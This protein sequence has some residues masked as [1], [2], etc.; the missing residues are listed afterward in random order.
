MNLAPDS[1]GFILKG[2]AMDNMIFVGAKIDKDTAINLG[3]FVED[4]TLVINCPWPPTNIFFSGD[5]KNDD[6]HEWWGPTPSSPRQP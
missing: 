4:V 3:A 2:E 1:R 6:T 5:S